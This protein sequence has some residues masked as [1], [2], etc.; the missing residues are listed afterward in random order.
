VIYLLTEGGPFRSPSALAGA[1]DLLATY[2]YKVAFGAT[3]FDYGLASANGLMIFLIV[4]VLTIVN[5]KLTGA[6]K[7]V[8]K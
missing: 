7:E 3:N 2:M 5:L 8:R 4:G 1:T 6:F